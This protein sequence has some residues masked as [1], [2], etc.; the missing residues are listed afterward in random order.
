[1]F[2]CMI[3]FNVD[4]EGNINSFVVV[5]GWVYVKYVGFVYFYSWCW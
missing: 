1:M 2:V 3:K 4:G 5:N